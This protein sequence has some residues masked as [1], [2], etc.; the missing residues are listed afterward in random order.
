MH[1]GLLS[2]EEIRDANT[3]LIREMEE[4]F[5]RAATR[6][7]IADALRR[8]SL[9]AEPFVAKARG[10]MHHYLNATRDAADEVARV[11]SRIENAGGMIR[12]RQRPKQA[13][14]RRI[15][16]GQ[17]ATIGFG[18]WGAGVLLLAAIVIDVQLLQRSVPWWW[19]ANAVLISVGAVML[20]AA[21]TWEHVGLPLER[22]ALFILLV[23]VE[24]TAAF[25]WY[26]W[27]PTR[28]HLGTGWTV[29]IWVGGAFLSLMAA[30]VCAVVYDPVLYDL[31]WARLYVAGLSASVGTASVAAGAAAFALSIHWAEAPAIALAV[32]A[33]TLTAT[34]RA[35]IR[36]SIG[37]PLQ[38]A[39][40]E[41]ISVSWRTPRASRS[42]SA[43]SVL[44]RERASL[45][46][47]MRAAIDAWREAALRV[48]LPD[49][50]REINKVVAPG[51]SVVLQVHD[52][53]G[54]L[55]MSSDE[56]I[57]ST[58]TFER[59]SRELAHVRG[60]AIGLAG[61]RGAGKT[62]IL[63]AFISGR[64]FKASERPQLT[65]AETVPVRYDAR[66]F[67]LHLYA[68]V[69]EAILSQLPDMGTHTRYLREARRKQIGRAAAGLLAVAVCGIV[70][71]L[72]LRR[73]VAWR[74]D[75]SHYWWWIIGGLAMVT[76]TVILIPGLAGTQGSVPY[77]G[78]P[79]SLLGLREAA[80][81]RLREV[82]FQ[83][84]FSTGWSG[85]I[86]LPLGS[87]ASTTRTNELT[88]MVKSY[89]EVVYDFRELIAHAVT[90]LNP[91][92]ADMSVRI[93]IVIDELDKIATSA[94]AH[95]FVNELK[96]LFTLAKPG[97][98]YLVS[99]S[100]EALTSFEQEGMAAR[101]AFDSAFDTIVRIEYL[102]LSDSEG[103][104]ARRIIGLSQTYIAL[105]HCLSGGL[106]RELIRVARDMIDQAGKSGSEPVTI[107]V[108]AANLLRDDLDQRL[109]GLHAAVSGAAV[110]EIDASDLLRWL[111]ITLSGTPSAS[112]LIRAVESPPL[113]PSTDPSLGALLRAQAATLAYLY[114]A[115]TILEVFTDD[116]P[117]DKLR[118]GWTTSGDGSF[119]TLAS[120]RPLI[121]VNARLAWLTVSAFRSAWY[122]P[123]VPPPAQGTER[124]VWASFAPAEDPNGR[125][126]VIG[127]L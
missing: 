17:L 20:V 81:T 114:Y 31:P 56:Y 121:S 93:A 50:R 92:P 29:L 46:T 5:A 96:S 49:I 28:A 36:R 113:K 35:P 112:E 47:E 51:H 57:V 94:G 30:I 74:A 70:G 73:H 68:R 27:P 116:M 87:E 107:S 45:T 117:E 32:I 39:L 3:Y 10:N 102:R 26:L 67:V 54:L 91:N 19:L 65:V 58:S 66:E 103:M 83:Q 33:W 24:L 22:Y 127:D 4:V 55:Q 60:G 126:A 71:D 15:T 43:P 18:A 11:W 21:A 115:A 89:P 80:Q 6:P 40:P 1:E 13:D 110:P 101:D 38:R 106:P 100:E 8:G 52:A 120:V 63:E 16:R 48:V 23:L 108:V 79:T 95:E 111:N 25:G 41:P 37:Q 123:L 14:E 104:L 99:V 34:Q 42:T 82:R 98:I 77:D 59:F 122:L 72:A 61:P 69:C 62:T 7:E 84:R 12:R 9:A 44:W 90:V 125:S 105:C 75:V 118:F 88:A 85:K 64:F 124:P 119:D 109:H 2:I 76:A 53:P 86:A 78:P 97:C